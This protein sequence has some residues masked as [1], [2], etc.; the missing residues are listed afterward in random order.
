[1]R[2]LTISFFLLCVVLTG[3]EAM[4]F[5]CSGITLP[6]SI[7]VCSDPDLTRLADERQQIYNESRSRLTPEQQ[8]ALWEDQKAW[9]RSYPTACG[10]AP[11]SPPAIPV[12]PSI[13]ECF[14]RSAEARSRYIRA[15]GLSGNVATASAGQ[16]TPAP[17]AAKP[18]DVDEVALVQAGRLFE[19]PVRINR[20]I[21]L[22]FIIDSG[23]SDVQIPFD[24]FSTL[25][26]ANTIQE[27]D[28]SGEQTYV[29]ADGSKK[30]SPKFVIR[31][32]KIGN[33]VLR[34]VPGSV[35]SSTGSLLLGQSFLSNFD[36]WT[37]DNKRHV[38]KLIGKTTETN[39]EVAS[40]ARSSQ[41]P[42][43]ITLLSTP[44]LPR[45]ERPSAQ[46][47]VVCGKSVEYAIEQPVSSTGPLGVWTG[48]WNN[49]GRLCGGLIVQ[50]ID[51]HGAVDLIYIYGPDRPGSGLS[52]KGQ[53]RA[54]VLSDGVLLF[55]DDQGSSFTFRPGGPG[56][57]DAVFASGTGRLTAT[58]QRSH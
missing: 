27:T 45:N 41:E 29:L 53:H 21:T 55:Q 37:L 5:N 47:A 40:L 49:P 20:A 17:I 18:S 22:N 24:V 34:D 54:G 19:I 38:L 16:S 58:F 13:I 33:H 52:W 56:E 44:N 39:N 9:V 36:E 1:M 46:T 10:V 28:L 4:A 48:N 57:L 51:A 26:R 3:S 42:G 11:D 8:S 35:G 43:P 32:L 7:V 15:Y 23:A 6:S 2:L 14:K 12:P 25:V 30:K 50:G 31:E